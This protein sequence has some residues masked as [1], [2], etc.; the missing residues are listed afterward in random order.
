MNKFKMLWLAMLASLGLMASNAQAFVI[1]TLPG[2]ITTL[3]TDAGNL[4]DDA[5]TFKVVVVGAIIGF[6]LV[7]WMIKRR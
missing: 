6:A 5:I 4:R 7:L 2:E 3:V 1:A